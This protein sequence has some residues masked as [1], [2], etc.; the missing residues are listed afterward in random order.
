MPQTVPAG[1]NPMRIV[2]LFN[3]VR[4]KHHRDRHRYRTEG[5]TDYS[6]CTGCGRAMIRN[7]GVWRLAKPDERPTGEG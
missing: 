4:G 7:Q 3:C 6:R 5:T 2:Q 1:A